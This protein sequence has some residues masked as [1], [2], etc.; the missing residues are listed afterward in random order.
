MVF[1]FQRMKPSDEG[2]MNLMEMCIENNDPRVLA[3]LISYAIEIGKQ[4]NAALLVV[5]ANNQETEKYFRS[6]FTMRMTAKHYRHFRFSDPHEI[7]SGSD[8]YGN[9]CLPMIFPPQ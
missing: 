9:V 5:W 7:N 3:S 8:N 1:D 6:T 4:N 2:I